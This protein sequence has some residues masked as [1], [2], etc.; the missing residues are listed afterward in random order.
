MSEKFSS[1]C[2]FNEEKVVGIDMGN[3]AGVGG[4]IAALFKPGLVVPH[5]VAPGESCL[6]KI[7]EKASS[8]LSG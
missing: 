1:G 4:V 8:E 5:I 7:E 3:A 2:N 6:S